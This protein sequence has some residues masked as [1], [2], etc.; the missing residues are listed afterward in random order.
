MVGHVIGCVPDRIHRVAHGPVDHAV[1]VLHE[2]GH[3]RKETV[4]NV[5]IGLGVFEVA[6]GNDVEAAQADDERGDRA[7]RAFG[8]NEMGAGVHFGKA[9]RGETAGELAVD[10]ACAIFRM[11]TAHQRAGEARHEERDGGERRVDQPAV[12]VESPP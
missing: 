4:E 8:L 1:A 5:G 3:R 9:R 2:L 7:Q 6:V 12:R 11:Q 10:E